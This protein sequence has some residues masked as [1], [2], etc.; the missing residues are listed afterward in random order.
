MDV[1]PN[2]DRKHV[3]RNI[4]GEKDISG[5]AQNSKLDRFSKMKLG[6]RM[7]TMMKTKYALKKEK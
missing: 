5:N 7:G 2:V 4:L 1:S 3:I 6:S